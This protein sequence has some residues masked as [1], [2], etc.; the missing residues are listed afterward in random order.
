MGP[1]IA[2]LTMA[3]K[4]PSYFVLML[5][6]FVK[7]AATYE[8]EFVAWR[9]IS[10]RAPLPGANAEKVWKQEFPPRKPKE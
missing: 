9:G 5:V 4:K 6:R 1:I 3:L 7:S 2:L 8:S 10:R